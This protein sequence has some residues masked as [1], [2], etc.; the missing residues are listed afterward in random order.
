[1]FRTPI[2]S[3]PRDE[4]CCRQSA[5]CVSRSVRPVSAPKEASQALRRLRLVLSTPVEPH[6]HSPWHPSSCPS[7]AT[8]RPNAGAFIHG[9]S[10]WPSAAGV[11]EHSKEAV[12]THPCPK[13]R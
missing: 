9:H 11:K 1:M 4:P 10:P 13:I 6:G 2:E 12:L 7:G 5:T 8:S 3:H